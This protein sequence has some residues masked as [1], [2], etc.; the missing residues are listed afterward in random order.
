M[1]TLPESAIFEEGI[2]QLEKSTPALGGAPVFTGPNP[3]AGHANA[4]AYQLANRTQW[5]KSQIESQGAGKVNSTDLSNNSDPSKG[6]ALVGFDGSTVSDVLNISKGLSNYQSLRAYTGTATVVRV[7]ARNIQGLFYYDSSDSTSSDNGGVTIVG[8]D[9]RRWKRYYDGAVSVRWFGAVGD[10]VT[11]DY[12]AF[13]SAASF[14]VQDVSLKNCG[15]VIFIP[16]GAYRLSQ[17]VVCKITVTSS[18]QRSIHFSGEGIYDTVL[19]A[20]PANTTGIFKFGSVT[21]NEEW[22]VTDMALVSD[23]PEDSP[24]NNGI[25]IEIDTDQV[26]QGAGWGDRPLHQV[27]IK[28]V[29]IAGFHSSAGFARRGNWERAIRIYKKWNPKIVNCRILGRYGKNPTDPHTGGGCV[30]G[31]DIEACYS[32]W[33]QYVYVHGNWEYGIHVHGVHNASEDYEGGTFD[34]VNVVNADYG[35]FWEHSYD[36]YAA[37][38][39]YEPGGNMV[40]CHLDCYKKGLWIRSHQQISIIACSTYIL[41]DPSL[42]GGEILPC[43]VHF[44]GAANVKADIQFRGGFYT[45]SSNYS[46]AIKIDAYSDTLQLPCTFECSGVGVY[47]NS[48]KAEKTINISGASFTRRTQEGT[49][50]IQVKFIDLVNG[51]FGVFDEQYTEGG[52]WRK[53]QVKVGSQ[54]GTTTTISDVIIADNKDYASVANPGLGAREVHGNN[55]VGTSQPVTS[56]RSGWVSNTSGSERGRLDILVNR[57]NSM[58]QAAQFSY[59]D[60]DLNSA[61][62]VQCFIGGTWVTRRLVLG[63]ADSDGAGFRSV[64]VSN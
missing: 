3:T 15:S 22:S 24:T 57:N 2:F 37:N 52:V 35:I 43:G 49:T 20:S 9:G 33:F 30:K 53:R 16:A 60:A 11:D 6:A 61:I 8:S 42:S 56:V 64:R 27:W 28:D 29:Q 12:S 39:R 48:Q 51:I 13:Q 58:M 40:A 1:A 46:A 38:K 59:A 63:A 7:L 25:A 17:R 32:P 50:G 62:L 44:D 26:Y 36:T 31:I 54:T 34:H 4:Q 14:A 19:I 5:L 45:D 55:S 41:S 18:A 23:L 47:N 21:N 10:G